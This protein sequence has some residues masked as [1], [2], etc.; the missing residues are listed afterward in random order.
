MH[1]R[2]LFPITFATSRRIPKD[3]ELFGY[4]IPAGV[5][6]FCYAACFPWHVVVLL[7]PVSY[8]KLSLMFCQ[9]INAKG[10][11]VYSILHDSR[12]LEG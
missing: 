6:V 11:T 8:C 9:R 5:T 7:H 4:H 3:I 10:Y 2:R 12:A 1:A